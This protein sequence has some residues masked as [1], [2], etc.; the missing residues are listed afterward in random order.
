MRKIFLTLAVLILGLPSFAENM[1]FITLLSRPMGTFAAVDVSGNA[2]IYDLRFCHAGINSS[3]INLNS[4]NAARL[5]LNNGAQLRTADNSGLA[6]DTSITEFKAE[7]DIQIGTVDKVC[8]SSFPD[9]YCY[10]LV[11][12]NLVYSNNN[13]GTSLIIDNNGGINIKADTLELNGTD[14]TFDAADFPTL[15]VTNKLHLGT[16]NP[17]AAAQ[18]SRVDCAGGNGSSTDCK[19]KLLHVKGA[20]MCKTQSYKLAHLKMCCL[21]SD[22]HDTDCYDYQL[23]GPFIT[24]GATGIGLSHTC[25]K[26]FHNQGHPDNCKQTVPSS[27]NA[28]TGPWTYERNCCTTKVSLTEGNPWTIEKWTCDAVKKWTDD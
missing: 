10:V 9:S 13:N 25:K 21:K 2:E 5:K 7:E 16:T 8:P 11:G 26:D 14:L 3:T 20:D 23:S 12:K 4:L 18:W 22:L 6:V 28:S 15:N 24:S 1:Q 19:A 27:C 17:G